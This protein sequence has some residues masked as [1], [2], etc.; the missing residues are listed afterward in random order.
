MHDRYTGEQPVLYI[1]N[2]SAKGCA[3]SMGHYV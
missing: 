3:G 2:N 1:T